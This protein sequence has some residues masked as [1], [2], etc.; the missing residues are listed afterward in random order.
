MNHPMRVAK[1]VFSVG[2]VLGIVAV[3]A[4]CLF[5]AAYNRHA[6]LQ[7][8]ILNIFLPFSVLWTLFCYCAY[9]GLTSANVVLKAAFWVFVALNV[10]AFPVG[11]AIAGMSI[12][13]WRDLGKQDARPVSELGANR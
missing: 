4:A 2:A 1:I 11:T 9:R 6:P 8:I 13:L 12:W 3:G 5:G 10:F 7:P